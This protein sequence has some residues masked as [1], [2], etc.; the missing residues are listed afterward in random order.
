MFLTPDGKPFFGGTCFPKTARCNLPGFADLPENV[1]TAYR[2]AD[3]HAQNV[4]LIE[5]MNASP[6]APCMSARARSAC[7]K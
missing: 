7:R 6:P 4:S 3:I 1:D 5:A 2:R